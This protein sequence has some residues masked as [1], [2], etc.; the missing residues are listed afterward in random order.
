MAQVGAWA[1]RPYRRRA[2]P[3]AIRR[4]AAPAHS[5]H[6]SDAL[7]ATS[8]VFSGA[9]HVRRLYSPVFQARATFGA[10]YLTRCWLMSAALLTLADPPGG[11]DAV[12]KRRCD[13]LEQP[14]QA[15]R[16]HKQQDEQHGRGRPA[17]DG[18]GAQRAAHPHAH[19]AAVPGGPR[20][21]HAGAVGR[22]GPG[23]PLA[24]PGRQTCLG[25]QA[26]HGSSTAYEHECLSSVL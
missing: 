26:A 18:R 22:A 14:K 24:A 17:Q 5:L 25:P 6:G 4:A 23:N 8:A 12:R 3:T 7:P 20:P 9:W 15:A 11:H 10:L 16:Q 2:G 1:A 21:G 13:R 19:G